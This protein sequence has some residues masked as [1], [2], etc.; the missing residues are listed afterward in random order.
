M[1]SWPVIAFV[2]LTAL[3]CTSSTITPSVP[4]APE[5]PTT[6]VSALARGKDLFTAKCAT[7]HGPEGKGDGPAAYVLYPKP[8]DF[9]RGV[10]KFRST[11]TGDLPT[12]EDLMR[13]VT[14]GLAGT[15]MPSWRSLAEDDRRAVITYVKQFSSQFAESGP[16]EPIT[17]PEPPAPTPE[18]IASGKQ[19]YQR[20]KC[21][22]CHGQE[23][24]GDGPSAA[25]LHDDWGA[26]I[27]A[28]DFTRRNAYKGG[29]TPKDVYRTFSTGVAGTPMPTYGDLLTE[30]ERWQLV[31]FVQSLSVEPDPS[32]AAA[33]SPDDGIECAR[34]D[35]AIGVEPEAT[36]WSRATAYAVPLRT[37]WT[38]PK[39]AVAVIVRAVT[40]GTD[41]A[42]RLEWADD[43]IDQDVLKHEQFRDA[44][45]VQFPLPST[46]QAP[47]LFTMGAK[48]DRVNIWHWKADWQ[49]DLDSPDVFRDVETAHPN[50]AMDV[51]PFSKSDL[52]QQPML[53]RAAQDTQFLTGQAA[54]NPLATRLHPSPVE[55]LCAEGFGTLT[56]QP[57]PDQNVRGRGIWR[58]G[59]WEVVFVRSLAGQGQL[60]SSF[61]SGQVVPI[62]FAVWDGSK[63]D[64]NGKKSVTD[65]M[66]L[67]LPGGLK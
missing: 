12:D 65:W 23:G 28:Y 45:A 52:G 33:K 16:P 66:Q 32:I 15:S 34:V 42:V 44:C 7:C 57:P 30:A 49:A 21:W 38:R 19:V 35:G 1:R 53:G 3:A 59:R 54:G 46:G 61:A 55:D 62:A 56:S 40:N 51:Y 25:T 37:L 60:D 5:T 39:A 13:T 17:I 2:P 11:P 8:R 50:M 48:G 22:E 58:E 64:R 29:S 20:M 10:F 41:L 18:S 6:P 14:N 4:Q 31:S 26:P 9:T 36:V 63:G 27:A 24:K 43:V 47:T 67:R